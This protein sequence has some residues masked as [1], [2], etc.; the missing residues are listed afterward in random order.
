MFTE[1]RTQYKRAVTPTPGQFIAD[2][3]S[4][5]IQDRFFE[6]SKL[7][8]TPIGNI[9]VTGLGGAVPAPGTP[10]VIADGNFDGDRRGG[11]VYGSAGTGGEA[12]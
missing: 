11:G 6:I 7:D 1:R 2:T 3:V 8:G 12:G 4:S 9:M 5:A 10:S